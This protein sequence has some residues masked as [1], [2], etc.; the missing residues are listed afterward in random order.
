MGEGRLERFGAIIAQTAEWAP[1]RD[2]DATNM[3]CMCLPV[4]A[5]IIQID[6][7]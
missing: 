7:K 4:L 2:M 6:A 3:I 1:F 5:C